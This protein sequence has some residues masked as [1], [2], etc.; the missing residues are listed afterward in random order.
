MLLTTFVG[1]APRGPSVVDNNS[2][3][4]LTD[5]RAMAAAA[6]ITRERE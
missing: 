2:A 5:I 4:T 1:I 6:R 3:G